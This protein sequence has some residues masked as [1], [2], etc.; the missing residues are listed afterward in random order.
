[1]LIFVSSLIK[2]S[3]ESKESKIKTKIKKGFRSKIFTRGKLAAGI[4]IY[5]Y[6]YIYLHLWIYIY[7]CVCVCVC[8]WV[9]VCVC[10]C[11]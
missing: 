8:V 1:M 2:V 6:I 10:V 3:Q 11:V 9:C 4:C 7:T 5:I